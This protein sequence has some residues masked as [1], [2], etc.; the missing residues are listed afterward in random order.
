LPKLVLEWEEDPK[1]FESIGVSKYTVKRAAS[2]MAQKLL[3]LWQYK[4]GALQ[5]LFLLDWEVRSYCRWLQLS[6][7]SGFIGP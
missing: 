6:V 1:G 2:H 4:F 7:T 3:K 5:E